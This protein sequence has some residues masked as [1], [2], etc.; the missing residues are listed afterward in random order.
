MGGRA[1]YWLGA[2]RRRVICVDVNRQELKPGQR[3]WPKSF[4][5][6]VAR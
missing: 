3:S 5:A 1:P 4:P 6:C 2:R